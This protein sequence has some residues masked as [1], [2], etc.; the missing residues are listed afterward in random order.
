MRIVFVLLAAGFAAMASRA[1]D[2][3][4][5]APGGPVIAPDVSDASADSADGDDSGDAKDQPL[6]QYDGHFSLTTSDFTVP[7]GWELR[8]HSNQVLSIGVIERDNTVVAGATGRSLGSLYV[9]VGGTYRL[10]VKGTSPI[11]WDIKIYA[12]KTAP[13]DED[14]YSPT[15]GPAYK[16]VAAGTH[17]AP[18]LPVTPPKP[19]PPVAAPL[20]SALTSKQLQSIVTIKGDR[21]EGAGF[22]MKHGADTVLVTT[23]RLIADNPN[24]QAFSANGSPV[25]V[26]KIQGGSDRD[27]AMLSVKDFGYTALTEGDPM[28]LQPGDKL[29][30]AEAN[31]AS[32]PPLSV[33][34]LD[35]RRVVVDE[36][37]PV[38]GSPLVLARSGRVV[39]VIGVGPQ[40]LPSTDFDEENFNE[41]DAAASGSIS[42]YG[43]RFDNVPAWEVLDAAQLQVQAQFLAT[44]HQRSRDLDAYL[45]GGGEYGSARIW[46][47][48]DKIKSANDSFVQ[49]TVGGST[50]QRT[51]SLQALLFELGVV[52]DIDMDQVQVP[53]NFYGYERML[54]QDEIAYR[55]EL[56][57]EIDQ[58]GSNT[59]RFDG[60]ARSNNGG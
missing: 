7:D 2:A 36:L 35:Q 16:P 13:S 8:W 43:E 4:A 50:E 10:R 18:A 27:V 58:Y 57:N 6:K 31:G 48:D 56:K 42:A 59:G 5:V 17:P 22:F 45:N 40:V 34:S 14:Y 21:A 1:E 20:P 15:D 25:Q 32:L 33:D 54:A 52:A 38:E 51:Q 44:F 55:K 12:V 26:T 30:T 46:K 60:V 9:P 37:R 49:D 53:Q 41:R 47:A 3:P 29:L 11:A 19:A 39:G 28:K 23:Q 24:W